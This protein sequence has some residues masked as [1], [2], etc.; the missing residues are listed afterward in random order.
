MLFSAVTAG[1]RASLDPSYR[2]FRRALAEPEAAQDGLLRDILGP[3]SRTEFGRNRDLRPDRGYGDF[4]LKVRP[5][6]YEGMRP[7]I[8]RQCASRGRVI[9]PEPPLFYEATSGSSGAAKMIPVTPSLR[10]SFTRYFGLWLADMLRH[11]PRLETGKTFIAVS[12]H[13]GADD[14]DFLSGPLAWAMRPFLLPPAHIAR[15]RGDG[16][17]KRICEAL[18]DAHG[19]EIISLWSPSYLLVLMDEMQAFAGTPIDWSLVWPRLRLLSCWAGAQSAGLAAKLAARL[20]QARLQPKGLLATEAP[21]TLPLFEEGTCVPFLTEVFLEFEREDGRI[22][23]LHEIE[24]GTAYEPLVTTRG[25]LVRYR[26]GDRVRAGA[27]VGRTPALELLGRS[28][29]VS[30]LVGEKLHEDHVGRSLEKLSSQGWGFRTLLPSRSRPG[31][32]LVADFARDPEQ[33]ARELDALLSESP[34]YL[35]ARRLGQLAEPRVLVRAQAHEAYLSHFARRGARW[36]AV[37]SR[38]LVPAQAGGA[39]LAELLEPA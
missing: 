35:Q 12:P 27:H 26:L 22:L 20:P 32:V 2:R 14:R 11:G 1:L 8:E 33:A 5:W 23:R 31:Y 7:W 3:L 30:D 10:R 21:V 28:A 37:K 18:L 39:D 9:A 38:D 36:G 16:F 34:R 6:G 24:P 19:L 15:L 29:A 17:R 25:G 13:D 4:S